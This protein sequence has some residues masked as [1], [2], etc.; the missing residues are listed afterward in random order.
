MYGRPVQDIECPHV[1]RIYECKMQ[2][3]FIII[4]GIYAILTP[5]MNKT[6][7]LMIT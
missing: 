1:S 2:I 6:K 3:H 7:K 4:I 5:D